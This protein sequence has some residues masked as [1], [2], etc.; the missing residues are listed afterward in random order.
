[1]RI[2]LIVQASDRD[3]D[4]SVAGDIV[5]VNGTDYDLSA[6]P[7]GGEGWPGAAGTLFSGRSGA[8][9]GRSSAR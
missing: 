8:R 4:V 2:R 6:V 1:M 9:A 7:E 3:T 5:T